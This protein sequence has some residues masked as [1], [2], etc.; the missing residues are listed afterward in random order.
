MFQPANV[1]APP[2]AATTLSLARITL[3]AACMCMLLIFFAAIIL[4]AAYFAWR[5]ALQVEWLRTEC[6][7]AGIVAGFGS[8]A[9]LAGAMHYLD[10]PLMGY[11]PSWY[12]RWPLMLNKRILFAAQLATTALALAS[13]GIL[14]F[15]FKIPGTPHA[16][17]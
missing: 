11:V 15:G 8:T 4:L 5:T 12:I 14:I 13:A 1:P 7:V 16:P 17:L 10:L 6:L 2:N 3:R 9:C